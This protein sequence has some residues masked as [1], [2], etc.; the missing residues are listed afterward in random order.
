MITKEG[1]WSANFSLIMKIFIF[2]ILPFRVDCKSK[3][4]KLWSFEVAQNSIDDNEKEVWS[5]E[6]A[7]NSIDDNEKRWMN[8][9]FSLIS[10][11]FIFMYS[12][13]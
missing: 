1:W 6:V 3:S 11:N 9:V 12:T 10:K 5:F 2:C 4:W 7:Q 13:T 8:A